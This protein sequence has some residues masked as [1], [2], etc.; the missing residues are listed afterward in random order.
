MH[1]AGM[2]IVQELRERVASGGVSLYGD[3]EQRFLNVPGHL[4]PDRQRRVTK[5]Q[6]KAFFVDLH[7]RSSAREQCDIRRIVPGDSHLRLA[8]R[9][10][11]SCS[12]RLGLRESARQ[13]STRA[14]TPKQKRGGVARRVQIRFDG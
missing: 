10:L 1:G 11:R 12:L 9:L 14:G 6:G 13:A 7:L 8:G 3:L 2:P 5:H 4:P